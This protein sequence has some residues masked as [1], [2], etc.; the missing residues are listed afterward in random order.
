MKYVLLPFS[1]LYNGITWLRNLLFDYQIGFFKS[2]KPD[3]FT[4]SVGNITV[5]GTGKTPF[6]EYL[7]K[8]LLSKYN[9]AVISRG[10]GRKT[11]GII[12]ATPASSTRQLGDEPMQIWQKFYPK[13]NVIAAE[14][15]AVAVPWLLQ[16]HPETQVILLDDAFQHRYIQPHV[17]ILL[18]DFNRLF[19]KDFVLPAGHLREGRYAAKRADA[20]VVTKCPEDIGYKKNY[21]LIKLKKYT[22]KH[23]I[24]VF[25][26]G[27]RYGTP[28][29]L[30]NP[31]FEFD[32]SC[33]VLLVTGIA[34]TKP[35]KKY[36]KY[37]FKFNSHLAF[38]DHHNYT[39]DDYAL[40][41]KK[42]RQIKATRKC[43]LTTEKDMVKWKE[44][45]MSRHLA[46]VPVFYLPVEVYFL[47]NEQLFM[48]M[49]H[50]ALH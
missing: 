31:L 35:L 19:F 24:P 20:I 22:Q 21:I 41:F 28:V 46:N 6:I 1:L 26:T 8:N 17:N 15:R 7:A 27:L 49:L 39:T 11:K 38:P 25:F 30:L 36:V 42:F 10:Y 4:I 14:Q 40:I 23:S 29:D 32:Y 48:Q 37:Q 16:R 34:N 13:V 18:T 12:Q 9:V 43:I 47:E 2:Y 45:D 44:S 5:G 50:K 3:V 33:E